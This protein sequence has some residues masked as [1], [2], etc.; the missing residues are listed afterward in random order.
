[1]RAM[2][3][4]E[5]VKDKKWFQG[6]FP[7]GGDW[8]VYIASGK[9][10]VRKVI[11]KTEEEN[12]V[13]V[14]GV[15]DRDFDHHLAKDY[16]GPCLLYTDLADFETTAVATA[17]CFR[18]FASERFDNARAIGQ[19]IGSTDVRDIA[20]FFM[21]LAGRIDFLRF[22][23]RKYNW[24]LKFS[25]LRFQDFIES[26]NL[27]VDI[28]KLIESAFEN[29][30]EPQITIDEVK[31]IYLD[32]TEILS[33]DDFEAFCTGHHLCELISIA[34]TE[35]GCSNHPEGINPEVIEK[36]L[37]MCLRLENTALYAEIEGWQ[38]AN[39]PFAFLD[40]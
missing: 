3:I 2:L 7:E 18:K 24:H 19:L 33:N 1:M 17:D 23:D 31:Q 15:V 28:S 5:G 32:E 37:R 16:S 10:P 34:L 27:K 25:E 8:Q 13:G 30:K 38:N 21:T 35:G 22:L 11:K 14:L 20:K 12:V 36:D 29:S 26:K 9:K 4:V 39:P 40:I 6:H